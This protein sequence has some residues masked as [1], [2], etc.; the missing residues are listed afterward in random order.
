MIDLQPD[1][2]VPIHEQITNQIMAAVATGALKAGARLAEY[3]AFAQQLLTN[4]QAVARAYADLEWE[5]VLKKH[6]SG[7][8]E[9][10]PGAERICRL[11]LQDAARRGICQAVRQGQAYG[12]PEAEIHKAVEEALAAPPAPPLAATDL[13]TAIKNTAHASRHRDLQGIQDLSPPEGGGQP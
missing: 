6:S 10:T 11:R 3:R 5:G 4:P 7:G 1:S 8:M 2:P 13:Q 9:V 12:L